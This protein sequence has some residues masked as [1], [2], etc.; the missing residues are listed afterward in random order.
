M[1]KT[2]SFAVLHFGI[3]FSV[4]WLLTGD[5]LIGSLVALV[6]PAVN[7]VGFYFHE[8]LWQRIEARR[9]QAREGQGLGSALPA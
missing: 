4:T 8:R 5:I 2:A 1:I 9:R 3:A 7:T 6:E